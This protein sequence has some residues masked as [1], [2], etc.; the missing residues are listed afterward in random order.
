MSMRVHEKMRSLL[1]SREAMLGRWGRRI[2]LV[3]GGVAMVV[4][5]VTLGFAHLFG[6][7]GVYEKRPEF[8]VH[9]NDSVASIGKALEEQ[10][11]V[12]YG[13][14]FAVAYQLTRG[15]TSIRPGGYTL[16]PDM[17]ALAV[18][19]KLGEAPYLSWVVIP[20][21]R[22]KEE[23]AALLAESLGWTAEQKEEWL[24]ATVA[25]STPSDGVYFADTYLIPSDQEPAQVAAR[26]RDRFQEAVA[27]YA[28]DI[29]N[30]PFSY[31]EIITLASLV[32]REAAKNDKA[33]VAG[34][35]V[36]R[37]KRGML[38]QVD[39][40][41]QYIEGKE[42]AWWPAPDPDDKDHESPYNTYRHT[43]LPP[44]PIATPSLASIEAV[45][46]PQKTSCLYYLHDE[47]GRIH[48]STNYQ[49]HVANV[50]RYLR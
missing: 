34:I 20:E 11:F 37:I 33:L 12:R 30:S 5:L 19:K 38:L 48:C 27:V 40:T 26:L 36:N 45:L 4:V 1:A 22:R 49:A 10:G 14:A 13:G 25:S 35:L 29:T 41:L 6:P 16:T 18:A 17:D 23:V 7:P 39:A 21:G 2:A 42:G 31:E 47:N 8:I 3:F 24:Q 44:A 50:N 46:A 28:A 15:E 32:E 9:P 43:G